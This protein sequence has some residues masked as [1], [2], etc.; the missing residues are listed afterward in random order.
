MGFGKGGGGGGDR[1]L[2]TDQLLEFSGRWAVE[3]T[4]LLCFAEAF[5]GLR[6][7][8]VIEKST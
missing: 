1:E 6:L 2:S 8:A 7:E 3:Q 4:I 5:A